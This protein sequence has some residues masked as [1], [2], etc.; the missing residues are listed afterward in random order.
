[1]KER[2]K[3]YQNQTK[4]DKWIVFKDIQIQTQETHK[5]G[6]KINEENKTLAAK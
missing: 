2:P 6:I 4:A 3:K 1:M 5:K